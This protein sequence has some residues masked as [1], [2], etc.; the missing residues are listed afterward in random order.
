M[1]STFVDA[2]LSGKALLGDVDDWID[3]WHDSDT[4]Q[5][6]DAYLGF[7]ADEGSLFAERPDALRFIVAA[8]R[9][10]VPVANVLAT[11]DNYALAA[12]ASDADKASAVMEW[13]RETGRL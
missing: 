9:Q 2:C 1:S 3:Q 12:R 7:V 6:L 10:G 13:L 8:R 4:S 11:R 5:S